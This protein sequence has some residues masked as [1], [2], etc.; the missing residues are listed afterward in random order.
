[1]FSRGSILF[2]VVLFAFGC[3]SASQRQLGDKSI[4]TIVKRPVAVATHTFDPA[5]PPAEMP[6]LSAGENAECDSNFLSNASVRGETR[7]TDATHATLTV[8][9]VKVT[10]QLN[11]NIWVPAGASQHLIEHEQGHRQISEYY[12]DTADKLAE[13]IAAAYLGRRI[14]ISGADLNV[15]SGKMLQ[16]LATEINDEYNKE[17]NP[18][19][20]QLLYDTITDHG[21]NE[22]IVKDAVEHALKNVV[23]ESAGASNAN[24]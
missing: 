21:R 4:P 1:L 11:I 8:T 5:S 9:G 3:D 12:Y 17:L 14:D 13:R 24:R 18:Q 6:P 16:Q 15:E 20:T 22:V 19:P 7:R 23:V 10:L 2:A